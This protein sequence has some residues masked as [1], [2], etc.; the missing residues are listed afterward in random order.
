LLGAEYYVRNPLVPIGQTVANINLDSMNVLGMTTDLTALGAERSS[1]NKVIEEVAKE[2]NL[3]ISSDAH[4]EQGYFYRSDH[5]PFA[6]AGIPA[7]NFEPGSK[8]VGHSEKW[9]EEQIRDYRDHRYHQPSDEYSPNWDFSGMVQQSRLAF[10][11]GARVA[12]ATEVP[13]WNKGDEF[14]RARVKSL[15]RA[16]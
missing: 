3:T 6:K 10:L 8:F 5:F 4:P 2:N 1:L 11:I 7:V 14:E 16:Q 12:G 13:Q 9:A 15:G